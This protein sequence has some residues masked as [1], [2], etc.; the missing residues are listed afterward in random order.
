MGFPLLLR[1]VT[2]PSKLNSNEDGIA[3]KKRWL[4]LE[5]IGEQ[6]RCNS[7]NTTISSLLPFFPIQYAAAT[8]IKKK[9]F[10]WR[11]VLC[12]RFCLHFL[13]PSLWNDST[14][15]FEIDRYTV[16]K[17][18]IETFPKRWNISE[19]NKLIFGREDVTIRT[20]IFIHVFSENDS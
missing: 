19:K 15:S 6:R 20:I 1:R 8:T 12:L 4:Q 13:P 11:S 2:V 16:K 17:T 3:K 10:A 14:F 7:T 18:L 5:A 9:R